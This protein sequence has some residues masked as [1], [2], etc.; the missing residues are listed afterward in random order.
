MWL[1]TAERPPH[2]GGPRGLRAARPAG[3]ARSSRW[4]CGRRFAPTPAAR[5]SRRSRAARRASAPT[6]GPSA[7]SC[8]RR[9]LR[10]LFAEADDE[11]S[12]IADLVA[13]VESYLD[14]EC[15]D[16]PEQR[17]H[18]RLRRLRRPRLRAAVRDHSR[19]S[20]RTTRRRGAVGSPTR[21]SP[22]SCGDWTPGG[23]AIGHLIWGRDAEHPERHRIDWERR[24]GHG[25]RHPQPARPREAVRH[26]RGDQAAV[27]AEGADGPTRAAH[28]PRPRR[29]EQVRAARR[30]G[31]RSRR[32]S[33]TSPSAADRSA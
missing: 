23:S 9:L 15:E 18:G 1:D 8:G 3:R 21:P 5:R 29:A 26:R 7:S 6:T 16:D 14:R 11:R 30:A 32:S 19:P 2:R 24:A 33:S 27:R 4:A 17:R 13:R 25:R 10:F 12:Q 20:S 22:R 28:V 31:A